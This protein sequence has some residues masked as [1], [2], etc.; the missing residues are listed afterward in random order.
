[1]KKLFLLLGFVFV[2]ARLGAI[3]PSPY[4]ESVGFSCNLT[5]GVG[6]GA[7]LTVYG[8]GSNSSGSSANAGESFFALAWLRPGKQYTATYAGTLAGDGTGTHGSYLLSFTGPAGYALFINGVEQD[9]C[10]G[11][12]SSKSTNTLTFSYSYTL[13]I[14][15]VASSQILPAGSFSGMEIGKSVTWEAGLGGLRTGRSAGR[16][17][18]KE[19][20]LVTNAP[21]SRDHP[22]GLA[23]NTTSWNVTA[24]NIPSRFASA[25][26][27]R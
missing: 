6:G 23:S 18:F 15:P 7:G 13:E 17:L 9:L 8:E 20:D 24:S 14:R 5:G 22:A 10:S 19:V 3:A 26:T 4:T 16:I 12:L 2:A 11:S 27:A 25:C 1:M 21:A